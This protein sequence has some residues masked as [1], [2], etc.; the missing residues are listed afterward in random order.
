MNRLNTNVDLIVNAKDIFANLQ[1]DA[2]KKTANHRVINSLD[3][4]R[5]AF[6]FFFKKGHA[7]ERFVSSAHDFEKLI[8]ATE[9]I[10]K[11]VIKFF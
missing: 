11:K 6:L 9:T 1:F 4:F 8:N 7:A 2:H 5:E 3:Q 10:D